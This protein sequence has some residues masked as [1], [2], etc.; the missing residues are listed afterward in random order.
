M[1]TFDFSEYIERYNAGEMS[2]SQKKWFEKE[3]EGNIILQNEVNLRKRTDEILENQNIISLRNKLSGIERRRKTDI[4]YKR[5]N[6]DIQ[7]NNKETEIQY[8]KKDTE[9]QYERKTPGIQ[10]RKLKAPAY[11]KYAAIVAGVILIGSIT[12][13]HG[14]S[15]SND[16][17]ISKYYKIYEPPTTQ[18]SAQSETDADFNMAL[19]FYNTHDFR[20]AAILFNK[21][22]ERNP[23]DM[24]SELLSGVANFGA[25]KYIEAKQSYVKVI[26]DNNNYFVENAKWYLAL[27]YVQSN[28]KEK[29]IQQLEVIKKEDGIYSKDAGKI[30]RRFK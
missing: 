15:L 29:A 12:L 18:R 9:I 6:S 16:E 21:V 1:K 22:V 17:I 10:Y 28:E 20:Q 25:K 5:I 7:Y 30:M 24:Q 4:Q 27:C 8:E 19:K 13:F 23:R 14:N 26:N 11:F 3:L 2:D